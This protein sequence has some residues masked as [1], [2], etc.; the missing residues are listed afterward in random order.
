M[1]EEKEAVGEENQ[2]KRKEW[3]REE[4]L[5]GWS[6]NPWWG[7]CWQLTAQFVTQEAPLQLWDG[8]FFGNCFP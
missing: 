2:E 4:K 6:C 7:F 3:K 5:S 8:G 1:W